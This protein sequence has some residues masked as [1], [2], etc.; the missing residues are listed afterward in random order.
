[1]LR[2]ALP[3]SHIEGTVYVLPSR[4]HGFSAVWSPKIAAEHIQTDAEIMALF[5]SMRT[6]RYSV[7]EPLR[8]L[9]TT[10]SAFNE[11]VIIADSDIKDLTEWLLQSTDSA[12]SKN[13]LK[14]KRPPKVQLIGRDLMYA[15]AHEEYLIFMRKNVLD[16][17]L[18]KLLG[19]IRETKRSGGLEAPQDSVLTIGYQAGIQ[20]YQEAVRYVYALFNEPLDD[21]AVNPPPMAPHDSVALGRRTTSTEDYVSSLW[22]LCLDHSESTFSALYM[23]CCVRFIEVGNVGGFHIFPLRSASQRGDVVAWQVIWRQGWYEC[24]MA[25]LIASSPLLAVGFIVGVFQ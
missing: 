15:L 13:P 5:E 4:H 7:S 8:R 16:P 21:T 18:R 9:R 19:K 23:F 20:G 1:M 14:A 11:R 3:T 12:I 24:L 25:Q 17:D 10:M 2:I 6:G 22:T